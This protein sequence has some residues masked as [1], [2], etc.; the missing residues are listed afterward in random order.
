[1]TI[2]NRPA[3]FIFLKSHKAAS[4][5]LEIYFITKTPLGSDAYASAIE[6]ESYGVPDRK[7][8]RL[9]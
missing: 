9:N 1:M 4:S 2:V 6:L 5:S 3:Q 8:T 7:S